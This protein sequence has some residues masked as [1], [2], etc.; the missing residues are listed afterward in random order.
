M[1]EIADR[2]SMRESEQKTF[3]GQCRELNQ[4]L[5]SHTD[6][7]QK[8]IPVVMLNQVLIAF[9]KSE[10]LLHSRSALPSLDR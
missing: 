8:A 2:R 1:Q 6:P 4:V 7:F 10:R 5:M 9:E 3:V